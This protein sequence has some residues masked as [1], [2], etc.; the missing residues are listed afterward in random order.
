M[1][2][3]SIIMCDFN[4][5]TCCRDLEWNWNECFSR[6]PCFLH[7]V[8]ISM[9]LCITCRNIMFFSTI[10]TQEISLIHL[11]IF[12]VRSVIYWRLV[13]KVSMVQLL[14]EQQAGLFIVSRAIKTEYDEDVCHWYEACFRLAYTTQFC[15][16]TWNSSWC[17]RI[18]KYPDGTVQWSIQ[19]WINPYGYHLCYKLPWKKIHHWAFTTTSSSLPS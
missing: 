19:G 2:Y 6:I 9:F 11:L 17:S 7:K 4:V 13:M 15:I 18:S 12:K 8:N 3:L 10:I 1:V 5:H 16:F 14:I